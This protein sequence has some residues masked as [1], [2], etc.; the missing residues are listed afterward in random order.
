MTNAQANAVRLARRAG[1]PC[2]VLRDGDFTFAVWTD[3]QRWG[4]IDVTRHCVTVWNP[5]TGRH[6]RMPLA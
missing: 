1:V 6:D 3:G 5:D 2:P 4:H